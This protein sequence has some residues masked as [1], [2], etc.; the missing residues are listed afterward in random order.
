[1]VAAAELTTVQVELVELVAVETVKVLPQ[2][3]QHKME[4]STQVAVAAATATQP[5][6]VQAVQA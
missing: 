3:L 4:Q 5:I 2:Q 1:V 6:Q